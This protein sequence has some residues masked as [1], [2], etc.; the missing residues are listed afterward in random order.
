MSVALRTLE[1]VEV[2]LK[3]RPSSERVQV[4]RAVTDLFL[5]GAASHSA[6]QV[7][8]FDDVLCRLVQ[9]V[10]NRALA[11]LS[12]ELAPV[13]N[14]PTRVVQQL[15]RHDDIVVAGPVLTGST[16][17]QTQDLIEIARTKSQAHLL[18]IG[19]R[20]R[21]EAA[22]TDVLVEKGNTEV[23][24]R[25]ATNAGARFS[26]GGFSRLVT[27]AENEAGL[28]ELVAIRSE[29]S[30]EQ[31]RQLAL[32]ATE[33]VRQRLM[34]VTK[35]ETR[36]KLEKILLEIAAE[37]DRPK[38]KPRDYS[39]AQ[40]LVMSM[41]HDASLMRVT[42]AEVAAQGEFEATVALLSALGGVAIPVVERVM[43]NSDEGGI[44][45]LCKAI[46]L[47]WPIV[48]R[49]LMLHPVGMRTPAD[50]MDKSCEQFGGIN[51]ATAQR[52]VRFWRVRTTVTAGEISEQ[53]QADRE[54]YH[55]TLQ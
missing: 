49:V 52:V 34:A 5:D 35:P 24:K 38:A 39:V 32:Q 37:I 47:E 33:T 45:L 21:V 51:A 54:P 41:R 30:P 15:A 23:A 55:R 26:D 27:R 4:L 11:Q 31:L 12:H 8:L 1:E 17:L 18:A 40:R 13:D 20:R 9:H 2:C 19:A 43:T 7:G 6:H 3:S 44:L 28:A 53:P 36:A 46:D 22:V 42:L 10:E 25:V 50:Q 48:R 16:R 29:M 14:A